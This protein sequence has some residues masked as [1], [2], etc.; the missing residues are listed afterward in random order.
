[1]VDKSRQGYCSL[2]CPTMSSFTRHLSLEESRRHGSFL[3]FW[4]PG[5]AG[6]GLDAGLETLLPIERVQSPSPEMRCIDGAG[7]GGM[8]GGEGWWHWRN[9]VGAIMQVSGEWGRGHL[10]RGGPFFSWGTGPSQASPEN[11]WQ[12]WSST[13][14]SVCFAGIYSLKM[15]IFFWGR[16]VFYWMEGILG[17]KIICEKNRELS[18]VPIDFWLLTALPT[19]SPGF[20][21]MD[22]LSQ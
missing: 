5:L 19:Y 12:R 8:L 10:R 6:R 2:S 13:G 14:S 17:L 20:C 11:G 18:H 7:L 4:L 1:M 16:K 15:F 21:W 9:T 22:S 3:L